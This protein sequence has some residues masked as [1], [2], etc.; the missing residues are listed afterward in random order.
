MFDSYQ[1]D[2]ALNSKRRPARRARR[3]LLLAIAPAFLLLAGCAEK[4]AEVFPVSGT[5]KVDGQT[6]VGAQLV[7]HPVAAAATDAEVV[8][9]T[10]RVKSDGTF[11]ITSYKDGDGAAPGEYIVTVQWYKIDKDGNVGP[12]VIPEQYTNPKTS[13]VKVTVSAGAPTTVEPISISGAAG[14][15]TAA[16]PR[17]VF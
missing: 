6:P 7:L 3:Q 9:P 11:A 8:T 5:I 4:W 10:G 13:P 2:N 12:N 17:R 1:S 14:A 16:A 15:K